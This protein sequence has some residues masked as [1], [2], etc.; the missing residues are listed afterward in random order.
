MGY[1]LG[2]IDKKEYLLPAAFGERDDLAAIVGSYEGVMLGLVVLLADG[3]NR[4]GGDLRSDHVIIGTWAG[5][6]IVLL[7]ETALFP[8]FSEPGLEDVAY[9]KQLLLLGKDVS[10]EVIA[11]ILE[12]EGEY[13]RLSQLNAAHVMSLA[14]QSDWQRANGAALLTKA[15][16]D[17]PLPSLVGLFNAFGQFMPAA[18][19]R[20][21][22]TL[23]KGL[24]QVAVM[25]GLP[26]SYKIVGYACTT[27][28]KRMAADAYGGPARF[29]TIDGVQ[30][31]TIQVQ[32]GDTAPLAPL[33]VTFDPLEGTSLA[34]VLEVLYPDAIFEKAAVPPTR[35]EEVNKLL[36]FLHVPVQ[37]GY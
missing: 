4:G 27:G 35:S 2:N 17:A 29:V 28:R 12:G 34:T 26:K 31:L 15:G 16:R 5:D 21:R 13:C 20:Q 3:N 8:E 7:D 14:Q 23:E 10:A 36:S 19:R 22:E 18:P 6:R 37:G 24:N 25:L 9:Q 1:I 33:T 30:T 32:V 11:A